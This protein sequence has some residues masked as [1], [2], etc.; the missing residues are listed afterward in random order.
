MPSHADDNSLVGRRAQEKFEFH[1]IA[2]TLTV[3]GLAV[4]TARLGRSVPADS[5]E[6]LARL[7]L[8]A[9]GIFGLWRLL[10]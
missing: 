5:M 9:A 6:L 2:L 3:L 4:Q 10:L 8:L 7:A 1:A